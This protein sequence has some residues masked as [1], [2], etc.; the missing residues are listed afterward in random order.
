MSGW[1][2]SSEFWGLWQYE[3]KRAVIWPARSGQFVTGLFV[4]SAV[5]YTWNNGRNF[6]FRL[7]KV[8]HTLTG[9]VEDHL[10]WGGIRIRRK[11]NRPGLEDG[12]HRDLGHPECQLLQVQNWHPQPN[13]GVAVVELKGGDIGRLHYGW[14][15]TR[16]AHQKWWTREYH[17]E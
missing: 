1:E 12:Q 8:S 14:E 5:P 11:A 10:H 4:G 16:S 6:T 9:A 3:Y 7:P 2:S 15:S 17:S 13:S